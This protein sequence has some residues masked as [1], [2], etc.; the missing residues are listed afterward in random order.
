MIFV[1][2]G[3]PHAAPRE[4]L[5]QII[6]NTSAAKAGLQTLSKQ[7]AKDYALLALGLSE[8]IGAVGLRSRTAPLVNLAVSNVPRPR[9]P[10]YLGRAG[11]ESIFPISMLASGVGLNVTLV[12]GRVD[13]F[14]RRRRGRRLA[15]RAGARALVRQRIGRAPQRSE[16]RATP[17][18]GR[19]RENRAIE[20]RG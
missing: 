11:L 13:A 5:E 20:T 16:P 6:A 15:R 12:H 10:L 4:R 3:A 1:P 18:Q 7:A 8:G 2:L 17:H 19:R 9:A 14:W